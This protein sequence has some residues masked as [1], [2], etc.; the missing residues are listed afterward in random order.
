MKKE[1]IIKDRVRTL[2]INQVEDAIQ[3]AKTGNNLITRFGIKIRRLST[4]LILL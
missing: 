3:E 4:T 2:P 1:I